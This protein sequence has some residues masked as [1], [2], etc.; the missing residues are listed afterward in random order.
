MSTK[1]A[2]ILAGIWTLIVFA[3]CGGGIWFVGTQVPRSQQ[4]ARGRMLGTGIGTVAGIGYF[5]II[6]PWAAAYR[7]RREAQKAAA[8]EQE[9]DSPPPRKRKR[10]P[11]E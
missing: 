6:L 9:E 5:A 11:D 1:L 4:E 7:K 2:L 3:A 10:R 8:R